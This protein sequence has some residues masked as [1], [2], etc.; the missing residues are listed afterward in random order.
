MLYLS[1]H[2]TASFDRTL[3]YAFA[4]RCLILTHTERTNVT[5]LH[6]LLSLTIT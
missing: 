1:Q 6:M 2:M 4:L 3:S 5:T